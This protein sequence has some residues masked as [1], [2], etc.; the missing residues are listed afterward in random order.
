MY[1]SELLSLLHNALS[2]QLVV[3]I[4]SRDSLIEQALPLLDSR[5][6]PF[7]VV[8]NH[9][10]ASGAGTHWSAF[11][12]AS[13][14]VVYFIDSLANPVENTPEFDIFLK[15]ASSA[16]CGEEE[17]LALVELPYPLQGDSTCCGL[18]VCV[19]AFLLLVHKYKL[20]RILRLFS[21][22]S[23]EFNDHVVHKLACQFVQR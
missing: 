17:E 7:L 2:P 9:D 16:Y 3:G 19:I 22:S 20:S 15:L 18:Y 13:Q 10:I 12:F 23:L 5:P 11:A 8:V 4:F 14:N 1:S 21:S 6:P